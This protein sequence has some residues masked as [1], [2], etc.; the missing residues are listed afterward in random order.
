MCFNQTVLGPRVRDSTL[1]DLHFESSGRGILYNLLSGVELNMGCLGPGCTVGLCER[2]SKG[3]KYINYASGIWLRKWNAWQ[4]MWISICFYQYAIS[5]IELRK[6]F[7]TS[8]LALTFRN[9]N[10]PSEAMVSQRDLRTEEREGCG[11]EYKPEESLIK[12]SVSLLVPSFRR[13]LKKYQPCAR[14]KDTGPFT[15]ASEVP[16][17]TRLLIIREG[18]FS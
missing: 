11:E 5:N 9:L 4:N 16:Q 3:I 14:L 12:P 8:V 13:V 17:M 2:F 7:Q 1:G 15:D 18:T 6:I 10:I